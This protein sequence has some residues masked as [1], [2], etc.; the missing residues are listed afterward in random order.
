MQGFKR[1]DTLGLLLDCG[2]GRLVLYKKGDWGEETDEEGEPKWDSSME[3]MTRLGVPVTGLKG[4]CVGWFRWGILVTAYASRAS[5]RW[6]AG[7]RQGWR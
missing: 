4:S 1:G 3:S 6:W 7:A 5:H 2:A